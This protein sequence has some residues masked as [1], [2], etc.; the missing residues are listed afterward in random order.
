MESEAWRR[1]R[2][3][4]GAVAEGAEGMDRLVSA[5]WSR[6]KCLGRWGSSQETACVLGTWLWGLP[7]R[8]RKCPR[9]E[10]GVCQHTVS[11]ALAW[12]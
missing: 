8:I 11:R 4:Q 9:G 3:C 5:G 1:G 12:D 7:S 6:G 10:V 2:G